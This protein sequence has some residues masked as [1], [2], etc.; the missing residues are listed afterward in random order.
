M[1]KRLEGERVILPASRGEPEQ[2]GI[3]VFSRGNDTYLV[4]LDDRYTKG[5]RDDDGIREVQ[6][7]DLRRDPEQ[8]QLGG[9][10]DAIRLAGWRR[11]Q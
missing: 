8:T 2:R 7:D 9:L 10:S 4:L 3:V 5:N 6:A 11:R 1:T